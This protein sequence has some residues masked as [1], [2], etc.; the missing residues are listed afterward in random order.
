[1]EKL[2]KIERPKRVCD[3]KINTI[4]VVPPTLTLDLVNIEPR[5]E[6]SVTVNVDLGL[7]Q[8]EETEE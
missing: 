2:L 1:M 6:P 7:D 4:E 3:L 5:T 8:L